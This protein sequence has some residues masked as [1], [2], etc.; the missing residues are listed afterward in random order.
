MLVLK[1]RSLS[2]AGI[3]LLSHESAAQK[4]WEEGTLLDIYKVNHSKDSNE[5]ELRYQE[6][7]VFNEF[8]DEVDY[9]NTIHT[10]Q[11]LDELLGILEQSPRFDSRWMPRILEEIEFFDKTLNIKFLLALHVMITQFKENGVVWGVGRGSSVASMVL[12][13]L[14]IHDINPVTYGIPFYEL[15]KEN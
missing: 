11:E 7:V 8:S 4:I 15:S 10:D 14:E 9:P 6:D 13:L 3:S 5:Y 1:D 12:Y 2:R